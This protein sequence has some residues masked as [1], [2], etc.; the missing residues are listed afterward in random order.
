[1]KIFVVGVDM[2][3]ADRQTVITQAVD[4]FCNFAKELKTVK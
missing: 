1:M 2:I 4:T 3:R